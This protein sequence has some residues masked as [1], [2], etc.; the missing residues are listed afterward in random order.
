MER[1]DENFGWVW[2]NAMNDVDSMR[3]NDS[4]KI[5]I[6]APKFG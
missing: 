2:A 4:G 6:G 1:L 5:M 3:S